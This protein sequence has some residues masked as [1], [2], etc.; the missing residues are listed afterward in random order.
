MDNFRSKLQ[1]YRSRI[2][3]IQELIDELDEE[4]A[5]EIL[6]IDLRSGFFH[7]KTRQTDTN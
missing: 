4:I 1:D 2:D 5:E 6:G 3:D 7:K